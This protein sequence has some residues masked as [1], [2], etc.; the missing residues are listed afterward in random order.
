MSDIIPV[1]VH[2]ETGENRRQVAKESGIFKILHR[3][4]KKYN[5]KSYF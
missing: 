4:G 3:T 2:H 1:I 5:E